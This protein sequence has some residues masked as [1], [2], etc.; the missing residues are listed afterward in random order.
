M[1]NQ[2]S[3][4]LNNLMKETNSYPNLMGK[5]RRKFIYTN[6]RNNRREKPLKQKIENCKRL[7]FRTS[8]QVDLKF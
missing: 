5:K 2:N 4:V 7:L 6:I 3:I 1:V 8:I